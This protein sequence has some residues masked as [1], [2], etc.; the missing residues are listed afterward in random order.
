MLTKIGTTFPP[1]WTYG[2]EEI[3]MFNKTGKQIELHFPNQRN[4][5]INTTWFG[6]QFKDINEEW[7]MTE[8]LLSAGE[9]YDN[10]FLLSLVDPLYLR[11]QDINLICE[12]LNIKKTYRL[13]MFL[14]TKYEY[15][16]HAIVG[17]HLMPKYSD[18]DVLL[19]SYDKDYLCYQRKPRAWRV[20]F[21]EMIRKN[22]LLNDGIITLG[23]KT[24]NDHDWSEGRTWE[25]ITLNESHEPYK[26]DGQNNPAHYGGIPNDLVTVGSLE[27]WNKCFLYISSE[28][29]FYMH[30]PLFANER[31]WKTMISLRPYVIQGNP[32]TYKW[33]EQHGF[34][35]FNNYWPN[36]DI[37]NS[38]D[39]LI[40]IIKL[41]HFL[42][43][44][45]AEEK[46][47]MYNDMV[48]DLI[49]NKNRFYEFSREQKHKMENIFL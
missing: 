17:D 21:A 47:A 35:T 11:D 29:V 1:K 45:T 20:D 6:S 32:A 8:R 19:K 22:N 39:V 28:T 24:E 4:L 38:D 16:F 18:N 43:E 12:K 26:K 41:L 2:L 36:I 31:I 7:Q 10:L 42:K 44:K 48:P 34:K 33:L 5:L 40:N 49:Y 27:V 25:P 9:S 14:N 13:G 15:N 30:E 23:G 3:E 46:M 37:T